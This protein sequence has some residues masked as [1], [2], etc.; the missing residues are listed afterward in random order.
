MPSTLSS[1]LPMT[2]RQLPEF[3]SLEEANDIAVGVME[4]LQRSYCDDWEGQIGSDDVTVS[5]QEATQLFE[6][7]ITAIE[8]FDKLVRLGTHAFNT[9]AKQMSW[10]KRIRM[11]LRWPKLIDHGK[12]ARG[13]RQCL[14]QIGS[15]PVTKNI[16]IPGNV[17]R[18]AKNWVDSYDKEMSFQAGPYR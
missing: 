17:Y 9:L 15:K 3:K 10:W 2:Q 16:I 13:F 6:K 1:T 4:I 8:Q 5:R 18:C 14:E 7:A 12:T 11:S